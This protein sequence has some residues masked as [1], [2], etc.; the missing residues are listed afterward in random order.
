MSSHRSNEHL[1]RKMMKD[2]V[3]ME[4]AVTL[5]KLG[6]C[7]RARV[8]AVLTKDGRCV[9]WGFNGAPPGLPHCADNDHGWRG[10]QRPQDIE[11]HGC[12]NATHAEANALAFAARQGIS[13]DDST[14]Y[15]ERSPCV[16][17]ARLLI[18][19]GIKRVVYLVPYRDHSGEDLL[20]EAKVVVE[21]LT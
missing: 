19:V 4:I 5:G 20:R 12:V 8:G 18:A 9:S 13:T 14:L 21:C 2:H 16:D 17:C 3:F 7:D 1:N 11:I 6:T 15:V 10:T